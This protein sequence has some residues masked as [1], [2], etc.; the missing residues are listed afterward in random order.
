[1]K[2]YTLLTSL[3]ILL[4]A[5]TSLVLAQEKV[6]EKKI[7]EKELVIKEVASADF[8]VIILKN[9]DIIYGKVME[10]T[11]EWIKYKRTDIPDGPIYTIA[12]SEVYAISYR[13]QKKEIINPIDG[14]GSSQ[15]PVLPI[16]TVKLI[17]EM[18]P[19]DFNY[20]Y[21][22]YSDRQTVR[23]GLG[24]L[25]GIGRPDG[26]EDLRA[27]NFIPSIFLSYSVSYTEQMDLGLQAAIGSF[28]YVGDDFSEYDQANSEI[29]IN[30][31]VFS[32]TAFS[33]YTFSSGSLRP[34]LW[35]GLSLNFSSINSQT[36]FYELDGGARFRVNGGGQTFGIGI[37]ARLGVD[38]DLNEQLGLYIDAGTGLSVIQG[39]ISFK[40]NQ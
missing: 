23:F 36:D 11:P 4:L 17:E 16:D 31:T 29:E 24:A 10:V 3:A 2:K 32:F 8:D 9:A 39:G 33:K 37:Q 18:P 25:R 26:A 13:N 38:Y 19:Q 21:T 12:R 35:G 7:L 6:D 28:K 20:S 40:I 34:Y 1:M 27:D 15:K 30:Q 5:S 22:P 14:F